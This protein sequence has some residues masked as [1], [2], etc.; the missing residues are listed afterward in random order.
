M[1]Q[2]YS[3]YGIN[4]EVRQFL[5]CTPR[6]RVSII[7]ISK[8]CS[9]SAT[10]PPLCEHMYMCMLFL[11]YD[12]KFFKH[13]ILRSNHL[14]RYLIALYFRVTKYQTPTVTRKYSFYSAISQLQEMFNSFKF[15]ALTL[16][17]STF[18]SA[19]EAQLKF[20]LT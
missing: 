12:S 15:I 5:C 1:S 13:S 18:F 7:S 17:F 19:F 8:S 20:F 11:P 16:Y 3:N 4:F 6:P 14:V 9:A 10:L 2:R